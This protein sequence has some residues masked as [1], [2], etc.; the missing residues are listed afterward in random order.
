MK[1]YTY[2]RSS[3]AYRVRIAL[4]LKGIEY[5]ALGVHLAKGEQRTEPYRRLNPQGLV[6]AL[7]DG[8]GV[9]AQSLA[10]LE[11]LEE[12]HPLP[13][14]LPQDAT[15]RARVRAF[16]LGIA[17]D[18]HPLNNLRVL[19]YLRGPLAQ[20]ETAVNAWYAHWIA[21]GFHGLEASLQETAGACCFGDQVTLADVCLV[22]QVFNARRFNCDLSP[23]P[24]ITAI[25][26]RLDALAAFQ[27]AAPQN[28]PDA[29]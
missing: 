7:D 3:A 21:E 5:E 23:Y 9:I 28:Q 14:L 16:C 20:D 2:F 19:K 17:C 15:A 8:H 1:L 18:I 4:N 11:Y 27:R 26:E 6:P 29:E 10:I 25:A 12:V 22:P 13:A 24:G